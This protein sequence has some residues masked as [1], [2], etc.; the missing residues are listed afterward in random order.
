MIKIRSDMAEPEKAWLAA[1]IDGEGT[2]CFYKNNEG[3]RIIVSIGNSVK[4]FVQKAKEI[5]G[6][7]NICC[8]EKKTGIACLNGKKRKPIYYWRISGCNLGLQLI[9]KILPYLIIKKQKAEFLIN[10]FDLMPPSSWNNPIRRNKSSASAKKM[11]LDKD[12]REKIIAGIKNKPRKKFCKLGHLRIEDNL[13]NS[14]GCK[15]CASINQKKR[16]EKK[17][18]VAS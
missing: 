2:I 17:R 8:F 4:D 5:T 9:P 13:Y 1:A 3:R 18:C 16:L 7:G 14:S 12:I 6:V 15:L 10:E 11:W